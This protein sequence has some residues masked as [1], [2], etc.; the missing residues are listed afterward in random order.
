MYSYKVVGECLFGALKDL[1]VYRLAR[2][3][4]RG[5]VRWHIDA[6]YPSGEQTLAVHRTLKLGKF[7]IKRVCRARGAHVNWL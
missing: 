6:S 2:V 4:D 5:N 3:S 1:V 7:A